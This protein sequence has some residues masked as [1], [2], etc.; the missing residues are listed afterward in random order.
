MLQRTFEG[1]LGGTR[2][3][4]VGVCMQPDQF[5]PLFP[6][7][8]E[9]DVAF[10]FFYSGE[11]FARALHLIAHGEIDVAPMITGRVGLDGINAA[12]DALAGGAEHI[13]MVVDPW[14]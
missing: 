3:V 6:L 1:A 9:I 14:G 11:E 7:Q 2:I 8:K 4:V 13:K 5:E 12:F 10:A